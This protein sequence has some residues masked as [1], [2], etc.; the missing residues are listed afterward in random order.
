MRNYDSPGK[1]LSLQVPA[2][3]VTSGQFLSVGGFL[4][5]AAATVAFAAGT[6]FDLLVH[7]VGRVTKTTA[8][9]VWAEGVR[10]Y[11]DPATGSISA[12][13]VPGVTVFAGLAARATADGDLTAYLW[14]PFSAASEGQGQVGLVASVLDVAAGAPIVGPNPR[15]P[16]V[17]INAVPLRS[18]YFV[19]T[20]FESPTADTATIGAGFLVDDAEGLVAAVAIAAGGNAWDAGWHEGIQD[21]AAA[22]FGERLTAARQVN[23]PVGVEIPTAG[24]A[25]M[26]V[27][28]VEVPA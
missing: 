16:F 8:A 20:T 26:F 15:G 7:G 6:L 17:P 23:W 5:W 4:G 2:A 24:K 25:T 1:I 13:N 18:Y 14:R 12:L 22:N 3:G 21:G 28:Y 27:E 9:D 10:L 19:E 11:F